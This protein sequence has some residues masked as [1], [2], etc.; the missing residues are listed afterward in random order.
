MVTLQSFSRNDFISLTFVYLLL[1][2]QMVYLKLPEV[3]FRR[4]EDLYLSFVKLFEFI[5]LVPWQLLC[6]ENIWCAM[7]VHSNGNFTYEC[8]Y[9]QINGYNEQNNGWYPVVF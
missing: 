1:S 9:T 3:E 7:S 2:A 4:L 8:F 5:S 6:V